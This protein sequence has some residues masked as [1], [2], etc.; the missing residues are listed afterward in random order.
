MVRR[1][2]GFVFCIGGFRDFFDI[3]VLE[4]SRSACKAYIPPLKEDCFFG[5]G[6]R[7]A[8]CFCRTPISPGAFEHDCPFVVVMRRRGSGPEILRRGGC[9]IRVSH[10][11]RGVI[12]CS[13]KGPRTQIIGL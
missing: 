3:L 12:I 8:P 2:L 9:P 1:V 13:L 11:E 6:V 10:L 5:G 4:A 7:G